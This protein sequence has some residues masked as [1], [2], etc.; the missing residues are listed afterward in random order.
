MQAWTYDEDRD[1]PPVIG[2]IPEAFAADAKKYHDQMIELVADG[3]EQMM[4][5]YLE[6]HEITLIELKKAIRRATL[7]SAFTPVLCGAALRNKGVQPLLDAII[8]YLPAPDDIAAVQGTDPKTGEPRERHARD[9]EPFTAIAFKIVSDPYVGRLAYFRVYSGKISTGDTVLNTTRNERERFGR[10]L[11]MHANH[12]E[13][14]T[15]VYAGGIAAAIGLKRTFTGD[16]L[17]DV[18][19]PILLEATKFPE[20]VISIA[21]EPKTKEDQDRMGEALARLSEEDPTFQARTDQ[22]TGQTIIAGMGEL[23]LDVV[24]DRMRREFRVEA[25]VG[26]PQV[27]YRETITK[28][29]KVE[30]RFVRQTGGRGQYGHVWLELHPRDR[31]AGFEF[32]NATVGGTVP[33]E[34]VGPTQAGVRE[35]MENGTIGGY[36]VVDVKV[37]LVDGSYHQVD[38]SE[39]AFKTAGSMAAKEGLRKGQ[40]VLLEPMMKMEVRTPDQFFGDIVGD[41][42]AR[43]GQ[44]QGVEQMGSTQVLRALVPLAETFGYATT[45][46]SL[47][48]GR[49]TS[50]LEFDHYAEVPSSV[51]NAV[52]S[53]R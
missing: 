14:A 26:R 8:D 1:K 30:G 35:A 24:V 45:L 43:R 29:V 49:A 47:S 48:Q 31:G 7:A 32:E 15:E 9:D 17:S 36:P 18:S 22:E 13:D 23:H 53:R 12:R 52:A 16:T 28:P 41:L 21:I 37:L 11:L 44:V 10:I 27:A 19:Q 34:Y 40:P 4:I 38:S 5:N 42:N 20:P 46:R 51:A 3:D 33:K 39:M 2:D 50:S 6:G 25:T